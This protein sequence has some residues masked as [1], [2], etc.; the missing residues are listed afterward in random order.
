MTDQAEVPADVVTRIRGI[1]LD[2]PETYE[3]PAW[4]GTRWR[5]R[6][7]TFAHVLTVE[8][9]WPPAYARAAGIDGPAV[10]LTFRATGQELGA[11]AN[12]GPP[13]FRPQW[14][15]DA[16]GM[17]LGEDADWDEIAELLTESFCIAAPVKLAQLVERP[18]ER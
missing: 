2:L 9:G 5:I 6:T 10:L 1:C 4:V 11:L 3:E 15:P 13:Y 16:A 8:D 17:V 14:A 12:T 18:G 7:K